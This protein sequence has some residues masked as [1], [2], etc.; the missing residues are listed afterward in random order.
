MKVLELMMRYA[1][2]GDEGNVNDVNNIDGDND[3]EINNYAVEDD[4]VYD[5]QAIL[6]SNSSTVVD[7]SY[8]DNNSNPLSLQEICNTELQKYLK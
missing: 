6:A 1:T 2:D 5:L 8:N 7:E 4:A 3:I